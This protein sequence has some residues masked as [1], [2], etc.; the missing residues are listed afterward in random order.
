VSRG[1][2]VAANR[3]YKRF[4]FEAVPMDDYEIRDVMGRAVTPDIYVEFGYRAVL[5]SS[6]RHEYVLEVVIGNR[7][8]QVVNHF[9]LEFTF[10]AAVPVIHRTIGGR[11]HI[12]L[13][14]S[15]DGDPMVVYRSRSVLFPKEELD[16]GRELSW[17]YEV[18]NRVYSA[19]RQA[20]SM[21]QE[22]S[23]QWTLYADSMT[24]KHG[25]KPFSD[26]QNY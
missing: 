15:G 11:K 2:G 4:N 16:V 14:T 18:N 20:R 22:L 8:I 24:P 26:L 10:P 9:K 13:L 1:S 17:H 25:T 21:G 7:G 3:Y 6:D 23:L 19:L 5:Q 12:D